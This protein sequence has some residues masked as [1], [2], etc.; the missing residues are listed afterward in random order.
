MRLCAHWAAMRIIGASLVTGCILAE[1]AFAWPVKCNIPNV[2][3]DAPGEADAALPS[4]GTQYAINFLVSQG[5]R[6]SATIT[7]K[8][9]HRCRRS[10]HARH[11]AHA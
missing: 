10:F 8:P 6:V 7:L 11:W 1:P 2:V 5:L 3:V 4:L 9:C